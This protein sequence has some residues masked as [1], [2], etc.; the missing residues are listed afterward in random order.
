MVFPPGKRSRGSVAWDAGALGTSICGQVVYSGYS[1][2]K[3]PNQKNHTKPKKE[4]HWR[5]QV[6]PYEIVFALYSGFAVALL[7]PF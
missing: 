3:N 6:R 4:L 1:P 7:K 5:V 2:N